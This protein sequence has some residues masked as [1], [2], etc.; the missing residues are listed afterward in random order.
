MINEEAFLKELTELSSKHN[1][2][3]MTSLKNTFLMDVLVALN[4]KYPPPADKR[5]HI[6]YDPDHKSLVLGLW[7][8]NKLWGVGVTEMDLFNLTQLLLDIE[9]TLQ[10][11]I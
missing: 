4:E 6:T 11:P 7:V 9:D 2:D 5:H 10:N 8:E 1:V 3:V